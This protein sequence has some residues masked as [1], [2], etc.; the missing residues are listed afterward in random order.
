MNLQENIRRILREETNSK[1]E[2]MLNII[3]DV[4]I[5]EFIK[6]T[7]LSWNDIASIIGVDFLSYKMM[8]EFI[9]NAMNDI[10]GFDLTEIDE[11]PIPYSSNED[12]ERQINYLGVYGAIVDVWGG[13]NFEK[14][15]GDFVVHYHNLPNDILEQVF[16]IVM[17]IY[18]ENKESF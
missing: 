17:R 10:G 6:M 9:S 15:L 5:Y 14:N 18:E 11:D 12:E 7:G 2:G 4:G 1:R 16:D 3:Q 8:A 13:N